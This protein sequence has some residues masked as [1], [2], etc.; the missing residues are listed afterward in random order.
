MEFEILP[1]LPLKTNRIQLRYDFFSF[2]YLLMNCWFLGKVT[3]WKTYLSEQQ[4]C[5]DCS[6]ILPSHL[7]IFFPPSAFLLG[8]SKD[9][10]IVNPKYTQNLQIDDTMY[11]IVAYHLWYQQTLHEHLHHM[12]LEW[13]KDFSSQWI[14]SVPRSWWFYPKL[15]L[16][17]QVEWKPTNPLL[18]QPWLH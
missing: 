11:F 5:G 1:H 4:Q 13:P 3:W 6:S 14:S 12:R 16:Q 2:W 9:N 7:N 18:H 17:V 15:H 8:T 10:Q